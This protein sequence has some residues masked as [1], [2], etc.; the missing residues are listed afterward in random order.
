[1]QEST[2]LLALPTDDKSKK[3][4]SELARKVV[5]GIVLSKF[6]LLCGRIE[7]LE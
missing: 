5:A 4:A 2:P 6:Q 7:L 3:P 1:M